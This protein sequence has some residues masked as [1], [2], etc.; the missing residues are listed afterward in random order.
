MFAAL[1]FER[2]PLQT[3]DLGVLAL[4]WVRYVGALAA[5]G[6]VIVA[7]VRVY[8]RAREEGR[9]R[10]VNLVFLGGLALAY[11]PALLVAGL[12]KIGR[13]DESWW[14]AGSAACGLVVLAL[15]FYLLVKEASVSG[16]REWLIVL[17]M[18]AALLFLNIDALYLAPYGFHFSI[19]A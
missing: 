18:G 13:L 4:E 7:M 14:V 12:D 11:A 17:G 9:V 6:L 5:V 1:F 10:F 2:D 15:T 19:A 16:V 3:T 8:A